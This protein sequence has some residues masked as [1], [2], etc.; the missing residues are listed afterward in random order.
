MFKCDMCGQCCRHLNRSEIY[1]KMD[2]GD[3]VCRYLDGNKCSIYK[4]RPVFCRV[5][6]SYEVFFK[7]I[8][9]KQEY[10]KLNYE[11]CKRLKEE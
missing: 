7:E 4:K 11:A 3:G 6:E 8:Y 2:R 5:D 9:S 1:K 10:Y